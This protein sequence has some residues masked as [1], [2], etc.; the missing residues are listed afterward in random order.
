M[1][2]LE[3]YRDLSPL[4]VIL[5]AAQVGFSTAAILKSFW[6]AKY[7]GVDI[8]YTLPTAQDVNDFV[9]SKVNRIIEQNPILKG[10]VNER[11][12][13][14][15]KKVGDHLIHY[16]GT[17][18]EKAAMMISSDVNIYDEEDASKQDIIA[19]Y[20]T[21]LQHSKYQW[22]WHFS[23]PSVPGY[24][25]DKYWKE[26]DQKHWFITCN[27]C[28]KE[29]YL[30]WPDSVDIE[31]QEYVCK[32]CKC[33]LSHE[34]RRVGKWRPKYP[35][36]K[37]SGYWINL[38]MCPWVPASKVISDFNEKTK[39]QFW[40]KVLGLPY[41]GEGNT[42]T[43]TT[44]QQNITQVPYTIESVV[45]GCD[46]GIKKHYVVGNGHGIF[47]HG[48]TE[49]WDEIE[50]ILRMYDRSILVVDSA[51]DITGPR[52]LREKYPGRVFLVHYAKDRKTMQL[53]R[54]GKDKEEG[55]V[56]VDRNRMIQLVIDEFTNR[57]IRVHGDAHEWQPF[58]THFGNIY[59]VREETD[60]GPEFKWEK[61]TTEDHWV[62]AT[63]YWRVGVDRFG[64][65]SAQFVTP[66]T[67]TGFIETIDSVPTIDVWGI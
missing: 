2:F 39:E 47:N 54:W 49:S 6:M 30:S 55:N 16:R 8:I 19:Q 64:L 33:V 60:F 41:E 40:N 1:F 20:S 45:I 35:G 9:A 61:K 11:D 63:V 51:P 66:D 17:W 37:Y 44:I 5:K 46:S 29:Q 48:V 14:G 42:V 26:S 53:I 7:L 43:P 38:L 65:Q 58:I 22:E 56:V 50:N 67:G 3:I 10:F 12:T 23:H 15:Q 31:K 18:L 34:A 27:H 62:H 32:G 4:Q 13:V 21:R 36:R 52:M 28:Q 25:V 59:R 57:R 24:G